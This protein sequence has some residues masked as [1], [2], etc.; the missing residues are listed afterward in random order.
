M[1]KKTRMIYDM[2]ERFD[3]SNNLNLNSFISID[4]LASYISQLN[5][6]EF[7]RFINMLLEIQRVYY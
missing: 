1:I 5:K 6:E 7:A 3:N 2:L 4:E